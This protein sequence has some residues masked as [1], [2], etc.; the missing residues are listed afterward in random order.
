MSTA[1]PLNLERQ[2]AQAYATPIGR[3][4]LPN[5]EDLNRELRRIVLQRESAEPSD[6]FA[7]VGGWHSKMDLWDW[8]DPEISH[9]KT[10][11]IEAVR[12]M[13]AVAAGGSLP[14][15][16]VAVKAWANVSRKGNFH[17]IHNHPNAAWSGVYYVDSG[18]PVADQPLSG[19]LELCDPRPFT[20]MVPTPGDPFGKRAIFSSDPGTM[21]LFP[22]WLY[23]FVNPF[24]GEGERISIAFNV[25]WQAAA[26]AR[27][28][29]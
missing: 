23:H 4:R 17:R 6:N 28:M 10:V 22:S 5:A 21:V 1:A 8:P 26:E 2:V 25:Q 12:H 15:G 24:Q 13:M 20:E 9:L 18:S 14:P 29:M 11:I 3:F 16:R 19:V 7:N 27:G